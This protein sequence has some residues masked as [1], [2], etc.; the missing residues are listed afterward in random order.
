MYTKVNAVCERKKAGWGTKNRKI[1]KVTQRGFEPAAK[2]YSY[3]LT[4]YDKYKII[5]DL[6]LLY[7]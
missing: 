1:E 2:A 4:N 3:A 7:L 5:Q 6:C